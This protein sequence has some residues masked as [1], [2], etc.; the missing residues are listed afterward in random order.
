MWFQNLNFFS[1]GQLRIFAD[2]KFSSIGRLFVPPRN[3]V[4]KLRKL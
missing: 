3:G 1:I 4:E 2:L